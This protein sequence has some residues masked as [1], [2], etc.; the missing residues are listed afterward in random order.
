MDMDGPALAPPDGVTPNLDNPDNKNWL[1][2]FVLVFLSVTSTICVLLRGCR[3][4]LMKRFRADE[5]VWLFSFTWRT[6]DHTL[7]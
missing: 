2:W 7:T 4:F 1:A 6:I 3:V 5:G